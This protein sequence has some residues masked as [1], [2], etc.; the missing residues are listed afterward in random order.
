[1]P[2]RCGRQA[3]AQ[4]ASVTVSAA[5]KFRAL[6]PSVTL[7]NPVARLP[8]ALVIAVLLSGWGRLLFGESVSGPTQ[9]SDV[10]AIGPTNGDIQFAG[11]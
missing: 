5:L 6:S 10:L 4:T 11:P 8:R 2:R 7:W 3:Q 1:V 9:C